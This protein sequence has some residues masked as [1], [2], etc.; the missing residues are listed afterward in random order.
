M[1]FC[2]NW[3]GICCCRAGCVGRGLLMQAHSMMRAREIC[4]QNLERADLRNVGTVG[5]G[6]T[7]WGL[8]HTGSLQS[9]ASCGLGI[10]QFPPAL[11]PAPELLG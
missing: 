2:V 8:W 10:E 9:H 11:L 5:V 1:P 6:S 3:V 4:Q 7:H